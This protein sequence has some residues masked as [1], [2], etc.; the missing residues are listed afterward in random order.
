MVKKTKVK[1]TMIKHSCFKNEE[2]QL[3][4]YLMETYGCKFVSQKF[5]GFGCGV[6]CEDKEGYGLIT[7]G[8]PKATADQICSSLNLE[9]LNILSKRIKEK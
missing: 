8:L 9:L 3:A 1:K 2:Q 4:D 7:D 5:P 6:Y